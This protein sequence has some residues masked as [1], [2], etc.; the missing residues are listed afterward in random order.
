MQ[1]REFVYCH[2]ITHIVDMQEEDKERR[3]NELIAEYQ[4]KVAARKERKTSS[5]K[6]DNGTLYIVCTMLVGENTAAE[7]MQ[8]LFTVEYL[9][10]SQ[11]TFLSLQ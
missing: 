8:K 6:E 5:H 9:V 11:K 4:A 2:Y 1:Q 3:K 7:L 10:I